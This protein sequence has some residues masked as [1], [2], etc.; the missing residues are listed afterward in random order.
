VQRC[1]QFD[2]FSELGQHEKSRRGIWSRDL[3][4]DQFAKA[5][6]R[7][8]VAEEGNVAI[9]LRRVEVGF[10]KSAEI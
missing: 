8:Y 9:A 2:Q 5:V 4:C 1:N 7:E 3:T 10:Q 6:P